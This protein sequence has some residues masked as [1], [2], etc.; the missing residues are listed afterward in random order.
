MSARCK[1]RVGRVGAIA[2]AAALVSCTE[3]PPPAARALE[4]AD[5]RRV[6]VEDPA[7]TAVTGIEDMAIDH[8]RS[9]A[10]LSAYDRRAVD[11]ELAAGGPPATR[12]GLYLLDLDDPLE[13]TVTVRPLSDA[14]GE[15]AP[16]R[17]P[18][19]IALDAESGRLAAIDRRYDRQAD[20]GWTLAPRL[21]ALV[22]GA[23]R[24]SV[25][26]VSVRPLPASVCSPNDLAFDGADILITSDHGR[27][28]GAG[29]AAED[30]LGLTGAFLA[31]L[32]G[33]G[34]EMAVKGVPFANGVA[35]DP[36]APP[37]RR[38]VLAAS[39]ANGLF[40]FP[41]EAAGVPAGRARGFID[42]GAAPDNITRG[43]D[44]ALYVAAHPS[45]FAFALYRA[46]WPG[47]A[48]APS[49]VFRVTVAAEEPRAERIFADPAGSLISAATVAARY[50]D[51]LLIGALYDEGLAVCA[52]GGG[53]A[54]Q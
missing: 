46:E 26:E 21:V 7:G 50:R 13:G 20:G 53:E 17:R 9:L 39:R 12:G 3:A 8:A 1:G 47:F 40:L 14:A 4:A 23:D 41:A 16:V 22:L 34:V 27:C 15:P 35:I 28:T 31:R 52:L 5:C 18:H 37:A 29:R 44:G 19:G 24:R 36:A 42:L 2:L 30:V 38:L 49:A 43:P 45:L 25:E 54:R 11:A 10:Y 32:D 6:A 48:R 33:A 51:R